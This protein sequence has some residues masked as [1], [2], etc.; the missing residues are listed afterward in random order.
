MDI[1]PKDLIVME[2]SSKPQSNW[3]NKP[4]TGIRI[5][6]KPSGLT[7]ECEDQRS[8]HRN[9]AI[10]LADLKEQL[11]NYTENSKGSGI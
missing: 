10:C 1:Q 4:K 11:T 7:V 5:H 8:Q 3:V 6:H 2:F 9:K